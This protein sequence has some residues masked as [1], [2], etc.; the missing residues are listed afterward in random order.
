MFIKSIKRLR[1]SLKK[2]KKHHAIASLFLKVTNPPMNTEDFQ[3]VWYLGAVQYANKNCQTAADVPT[4]VNKTC[5]ER[6]A[7]SK[8]DKPSNENDGFSCFCV[9]GCCLIFSSFHEAIARDPKGTTAALKATLWDQRAT[10]WRP[11]GPTLGPLG[12]HLGS[13]YIDKLPINRPSGRYV[14]VERDVCTI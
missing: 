10:T 6:L 5:S 9:S 1:R 8:S 3:F 12:A 13:L 11:L 7:F 4:K 2:S 14:Y